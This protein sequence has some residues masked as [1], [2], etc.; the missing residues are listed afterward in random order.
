MEGK[1]YKTSKKVTGRVVNSI[2]PHA[3]FISEVTKVL[4]CGIRDINYVYQTQIP[5]FPPPKTGCKAVLDH[6]KQISSGYLDSI[7]NGNDHP[8]KP[9]LRH[10]KLKK[11]ASIGASLVSLKKLLPP[12]CQCM[13]P[14]LEKKH[15]QLM[16]KPCDD[17]P[18]DFLS[19]VDKE[20]YKLFKNGWDKKYESQVRKACKPIKSSFNVSKTDGGQHKAYNGSREEYMRNCLNN[21][22]HFLT[23]PIVKYSL[24]HDKGKSR[25]ITINHPEHIEL[26]PLHKTIYN[27]LSRNDFI[28]RGPPTSHILN[29][30][31]G[32]LRKGEVLVSADYESATD[33]FNPIISSR[34]LDQI[35][36]TSQ[37]IP[38]R[39]RDMAS[40]SLKSRIQYSDG[41]IEPVRGQLMGNFLSFPL[42]CLYNYVCL[43]YYTQTTKFLINGDDLLM[44]INKEQFSLWSENLERL[45]LKLSMGKTAVTDNFASINSTYFWRRWSR[46]QYLPFLRMG[47]L[48][49]AESQFFQQVADNIEEFSKGFD[50]RDMISRVKAIYMQRHKDTLIYSGMSLTL[51]KPIGLG[52]RWK[53][54]QL[55]RFHLDT[56]EVFAVRNFRKM[57]SVV[58]PENNF[59]MPDDLYQDDEPP[60]KDEEDFITEAYTAKNWST[61]LTYDRSKLAIFKENVE[62][63]SIFR[64]FQRWRKN[65]NKK[66]EQYITL[67]MGT[68]YEYKVK[69][70]KISTTIEDVSIKNAYKIAYG[71]LKNVKQKFYRSSSYYD[72]QYRP[73][74]LLHYIR[75]RYG[76]TRSSSYNYTEPEL[77]EV[78]NSDFPEVI[79][80][81]TC[82]P[83]INRHARFVDLDPLEDL[84]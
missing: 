21:Q 17:L 34:I 7:F 57:K 32:G 69:V 63:T 48:K 72:S 40:G 20:I 84:N 76:R 82:L 70:S 39:I 41:I 9:F 83:A 52:M 4:S 28:L 35:L 3:R 36:K 61:S 26:K 15:R 31:L 56:Y 5:L 58:P 81:S 22:D 18:E 65:N 2:A 11:R 75:Y 67:F 38:T 13:N 43:R 55:K 79:F 14:G 24:I 64:K 51:P 27:H 6:F 8:I 71:Y 16:E 33:N 50:D 73:D 45:G 77:P 54:P 59:T 12:P 78:N 1:I 25:G 66:E 80:N 60:S 62:F 53:I 49:K 47:L 10:L 46:Y 42:L 30:R 23:L 37:Y 29:L 19:F 68:E 74:R 44:V